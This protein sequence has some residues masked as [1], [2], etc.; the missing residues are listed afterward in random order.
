ML[1]TISL[2][3]ADG[4]WCG[5]YDMPG[6]RKEILR[7]VAEKVAAL[8]PHPKNPTQYRMGKARVSRPIPVLE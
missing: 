3:D 6:T 1:T 4:R 7:T 2:Y 5:S 8:P